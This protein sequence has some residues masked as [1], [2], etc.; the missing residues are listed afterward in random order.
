[1]RACFDEIIAFAELQEFVDAKVKELS[2]GMRQRLTFAITSR[3]DSDLL[4]LDEILAVGDRNFREKSYA[5]FQQRRQE[6]KS[7]ILASHDLAAVAEL[8]DQSLLLDHG[9]QRA[10]GPTAEVLSIY[11]SEGQ[12][13]LSIEVGAAR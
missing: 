3:L 10:F 2:T 4:L 8:C 7:L 13:S 9:H 12:K 1:V 11:A 5:V 6:G